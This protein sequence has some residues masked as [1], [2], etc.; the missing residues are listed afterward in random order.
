MT[1]F[2]PHYPL[3]DQHSYGKLIYI[4]M[5]YPWNIL[6]F[7]FSIAMLNYLRLPLPKKVAIWRVPRQ[8]H[9][10]THG[11]TCDL[12]DMGLCVASCHGTWESDGP[13]AGRL[14]GLRGPWPHG[15]LWSW[16]IKTGDFM[17]KTLGNNWG[18]DWI[19]GEDNYYFATTPVSLM[20]KTMVSIGIWYD[21]WWSIISIFGFVG[22]FSFPKL[23]GS[24]SSSSSTTWK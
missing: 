3:V 15:Y 17:G 21:Q 12:I 8:N 19:M 18:K 24:S 6:T 7:W 20:I 5:I 14:K 23:D 9:W 22:T 1:Q 11:K 2:Y 16:G 10:K 13:T 4:Y